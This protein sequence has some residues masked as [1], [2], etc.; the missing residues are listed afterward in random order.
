MPG[1]Y[2][3]D[4]RVV[5]SYNHYH[6]KQLTELS[7][8]LE[9]TKQIEAIKMPAADSLA[10]LEYNCAMPLKDKIEGCDVYFITTDISSD[11]FEVKEKSNDEEEVKDKL[12]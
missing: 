7:A 8:L 2:D 11:S 10:Y 3:L 6:L 5:F 1:S 9:Y 12:H 4:L